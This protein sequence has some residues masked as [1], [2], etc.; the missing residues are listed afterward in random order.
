MTS[1]TNRKIVIAKRAF[2]V[3]TG[4]TALASSAGVMIQRRRRRD[5]ASLRHTGAHLMAVVTVSFWIMLSVTEPDSERGHVL[6]CARIYAQLMTSAAGRDVASIYLPARRVTAKTGCVRV[7]ISRDG[8][9]DPAA[10]RTMTS[11]A[12][13]VSQRDV[14]GMIELHSETC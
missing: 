6:R 13:H 8:H 5:L 2:A 14:S 7:E 11:R 1:L 12:T 3:M 10:H 9:G 4:R